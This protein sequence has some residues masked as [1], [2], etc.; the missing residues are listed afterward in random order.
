MEKLITRGICIIEVAELKIGEL[1]FPI[2]N[3]EQFRYDEAI[4]DSN[5][6]YLINRYACPYENEFTLLLGGPR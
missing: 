2:K 6:I 3:R 1:L 4:N 5:V